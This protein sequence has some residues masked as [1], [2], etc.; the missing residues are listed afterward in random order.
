MKAKIKQTGEIV[1]VEPL[2]YA[3]IGSVEPM[4]HKN[5]IELLE[6]NTDI[7]DEQR[8]YEIAKAMLPVIY[9]DDGQAERADDS[10]VGFEYK[11]DRHCAKEA[12]DFADALI[13][14][15]KKRK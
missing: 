7:G 3:K 5:D 14:E 12:V 2:F 15:L 1:A 9:L 13:E 10:D 6:S 4:M 11:S 8:R